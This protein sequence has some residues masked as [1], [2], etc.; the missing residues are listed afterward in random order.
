MSN[1]SEGCQIS[2]GRCCNNLINGIG[3]FEDGTF[4]LDR[5]EL[6]KLVQELR[7]RIEEFLRG[8]CNQLPS[9]IES[10][11]R[12]QSQLHCDRDF[13]WGVRFT[14]CE[15]RNGIDFAE[16]TIVKD[17]TTRGVFHEPID[18]T[19]EQFRVPVF[20][21]PLPKDE[22]SIEVASVIDDRLWS[23][24]VGALI[25]PILLGLLLIELHL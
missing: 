6:F 2:T 1:C 18:V 3:C 25:G 17:T 24:I 9:Q 5:T 16:S 7:R 10:S 8:V 22:I 23:L 4:S 12:I 15:H 19:V 20:R 13:H 14:L 21:S 11:P